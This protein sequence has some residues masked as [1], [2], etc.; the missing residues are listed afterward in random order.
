[1][2]GITSKVVLRAETGAA[3][4]LARRKL[5]L[6]CPCVAINMALLTERSEL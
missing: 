4:V 6:G 5:N 3:H 1:M 2:A